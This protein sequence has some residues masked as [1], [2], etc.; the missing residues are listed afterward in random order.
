MRYAPVVQD[1]QPIGQR[2]RVGGVPGHVDGRHR[3]IAVQLGELQSQR[4][5]R[6]RI[7]VGERL[8]EQQHARLDG[9]G[10]GQRQATPLGEPER[11]RPAV[12]A[13]GQ[14]E[15]ADHQFHASRDVGRRHPLLLEAE[16][17]V[18]THGEM[19][20]QRAL[21]KDVAG[22]AAPRWQRGDVLPIHQDP[23]AR[24]RHEAGHGLEHVGLAGV[25]RP[26][27]REELAVAHVHRHLIEPGRPPLPRRE[28]VEPD[29]DERPAHRGT[30]GTW[31]RIADSGRQASP[32]RARTV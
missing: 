25:R 1:G 13:G 16:R 7:E 29:V 14:P 32:A 17:H 20:P 4:L 27:E 21:L 15:A 6:E 23:A 9:Q 22:R 19:R 2:E 31:A 28:R 24:H 12:D 18:L 30:A 3:Q 26:Q 10:P 8:V 5:A 11:G